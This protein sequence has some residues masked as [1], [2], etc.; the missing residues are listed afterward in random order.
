MNKSSVQYNNIIILFQI[1]SLYIYMTSSSKQSNKKIS[2]S[3]HCEEQSQKNW[4]H[5]ST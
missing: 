2:S 1:L 5:N 4:W 3:T